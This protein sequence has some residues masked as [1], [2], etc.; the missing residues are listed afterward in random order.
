[1]IA[2]KISNHEVTEHFLQIKKQ[3]DM[4]T[5]SKSNELGFPDAGKTKTKSIVDYKLTRYAC[6]L[7][8]MNGDPRKSIIA[9]GQTYFA[10]KTRQ[11]EFQELYHQLGEEEKKY[12]SAVIK[13]FR[14][15]VKYIANVIN[16]GENN[17]ID[18][19]L[20]DWSFALPNFKKGTMYNGMEPDKRYTLKEL[21]L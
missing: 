2:C 3:V 10:V 16:Y 18:I 9:E 13:P 14:D 17:Y 8:V 19:V 7:I 5:K 15:R 6:Y 12:L 20:N 1:M 21:G 4:P 11:Q